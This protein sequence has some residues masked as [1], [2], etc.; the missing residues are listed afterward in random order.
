MAKKTTS[1]GIGTS[2]EML[3][4]KTDVFKDQVSAK[5][6]AEK[7]KEPPAP[8]VICEERFNKKEITLLKMLV[9]ERAD[10]SE[11][12][13]KEHA[14]YEEATEKIKSILNDYGLYYLEETKSVRWELDFKEQSTTRIV[15]DKARK[16]LSEGVL[17][18][19]SDTT[20]STPLIVKLKPIP[21]K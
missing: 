5:A 20:L 2:S 19:I 7:E 3:A 15:P 1:T 6:K 13:K 4:K 18:Q 12:E 17:A 16:L 21:I 10:A 11:A 9:K 8:P 14:R